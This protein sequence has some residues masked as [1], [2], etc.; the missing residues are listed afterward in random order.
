MNINFSGF[1]TGSATSLCRTSLKASEVF[2]KYFWRQVQP[3][4]Y[5]HLNSAV[6]IIGCCMRSICN[7]FE[8]T[9]QQH[10]ILW[11]HFIQWGFS[12]SNRPIKTLIKL[13][14]VYKVI[15][16]LSLQMLS[17]WQTLRQKTTCS[18]LHRAHFAFSFF[19]NVTAYFNFAFFRGKKFQNVY[20]F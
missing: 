15:S 12:F 1:P 13:L 2:P 14:S 5:S 10:N 16:R 4:S 3:K 17:S 11:S 6:D 7:L 18:H 8:A 20:Y 9:A 19:P